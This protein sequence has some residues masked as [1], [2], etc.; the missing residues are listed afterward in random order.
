[1]RSDGAAFGETVPISA[2]G[3]LRYDALEVLTGKF[4]VKRLALARI[5]K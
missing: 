5:L 1:M 2:V 3:T 4:H